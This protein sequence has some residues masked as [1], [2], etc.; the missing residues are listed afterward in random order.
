MAA[1]AGID[2]SDAEAL[3]FR[4]QPPWHRS[5]LSS[6]GAKAAVSIQ[7]PSA[8]ERLDNLIKVRRAGSS[9]L[10]NLRKDEVR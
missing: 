2:R 7:S 9:G 10:I 8:L 4:T 1:V 3:T 5:T 6:P